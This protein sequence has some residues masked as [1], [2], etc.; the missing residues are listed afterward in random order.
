MF[1]TRDASE[2]VVCHNDRVAREIF[3]DRRRWPDVILMGVGSVPQ[4][5][6]VKEFVVRIPPDWRGVLFLTD[7]EFSM[8]RA[9]RGY[10][11]DYTRYRARL[12]RLT[13]AMGDGRVRWV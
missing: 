11:E 6:G 12:E 4:N 13:V 2:A 8:R 3:E 7:W 5:C 1:D 10:R 9:G